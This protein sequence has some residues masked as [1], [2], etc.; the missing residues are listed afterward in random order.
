MTLRKAM[1]SLWLG[2]LLL[3]APGCLS[4]A[5]NLGAAT[6]PV[7]TTEVGVS[8]NA[9]AFEHGRERAYLPNPELTFR[10]GAGENWDWGGRLTLLGLELGTR[11][12]LVERSPWT[13]SLAPSAGVW[14]VPVTNNSTEPV[15]LRL[16]GQALVDY[17]LSPAW[18][19]T[20]GAS[21][22][23]AFAGPLT[24]FQGRF[25]GSHLLA[26][27]GGSLG[28]A[29]RLGKSLEIRAEAGLELPLDLREG[30]RQVTGHAGLSLRWRRA[31][32]R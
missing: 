1:R 26:L 16:G 27:P 10:K 18:T 24:V 2:G 15:N 11:H 28:V 14:Y 32:A 8:L 3:L 25:N 4:G 21:L 9:L 20:G 23:G 30:R 17:R 19:L 6:T 7:G 12:R 29:Y 22:M 5:R 13:L 31:N